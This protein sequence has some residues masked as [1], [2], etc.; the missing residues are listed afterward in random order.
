MGEIWGGLTLQGIFFSMN[1]AG[2]TAK[3][4]AD[5]LNIS[6]LLSDSG[7]GGVFFCLYK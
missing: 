2:N 7:A 3:S 5:S 6:A 1:K 4:S